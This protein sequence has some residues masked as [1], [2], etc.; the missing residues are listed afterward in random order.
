[1]MSFN[2]GV[3]YPSLKPPL[4]YKDEALRLNMYQ[5]L[6]KKLIKAHAKLKNNDILEAGCGRGLG[7]KYIV[8]NFSPKS[9]VGI[10][11]SGNSL[12]VAKKANSVDG[13]IKFIEGDVHKLPFSDNSFGLVI[14]VESSH[15]Y[16]DFSLFLSEVN[17]V[18]K[19]DGYFGFVDFRD[20]TQMPKLVEDM[21]KNG[22]QI[23]LDENITKY[24]LKA[25][26]K[27]ED[28]K[29]MII[30]KRAHPLLKPFFIRFAG[31]EGTGMRSKFQSGEAQY[32]L[33]IL[34][35]Q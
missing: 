17:R 13:F 19:K 1:M 11:I 8:Q 3:D 25:L 34:R 9:Y 5:L 32:W 2:F 20:K 35:R 18:L 33:F 6:A 4:R 28:Q 27:E 29:R 24:V 15:W 7:A 12:K 23:V 14:N 30:E 26:P 16:K 31:L 22:L 10:D 21:K